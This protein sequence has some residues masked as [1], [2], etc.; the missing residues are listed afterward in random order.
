MALI[1]RKSSAK[2]YSIAKE[3]AEISLQFDQN[4]ATDKS[5]I[6]VTRDELAGSKIHYRFIKKN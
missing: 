5:F 6:T 3:L 2:S 1:Y 4:I